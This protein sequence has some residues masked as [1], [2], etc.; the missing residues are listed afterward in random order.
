MTLESCPQS[1]HQRLADG[2]NSVVAPVLW[3][4]EVE[5]IRVADSLSVLDVVATL[6]GREERVEKIASC[7]RYVQIL[8]SYGRSPSAGAGEG[9]TII[10][11]TF[12]Q[13]LGKVTHVP[14][15]V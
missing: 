3:R 2:Q 15:Q 11:A 7:A 6:F 5:Q 4:E 8:A 10:F 12:A 14:M 13:R 9:S 1:V